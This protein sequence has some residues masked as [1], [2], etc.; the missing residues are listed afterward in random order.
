[1]GLIK[2]TPAQLRAKA[3]ELKKQNSAFKKDVEALV[4][5][6]GSLKSMWEGEAN[7]AFHTAFMKDK[8]KFD[9]FSQAIEEY[10]QKLEMIATEYE[11]AEKKNVGIA[12]R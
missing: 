4:A 11:N 6:E 12:G 3:G 2:V 5:K 9:L 7:T 8:A 1:M 10:A